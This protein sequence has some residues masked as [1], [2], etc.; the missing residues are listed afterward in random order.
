VT[1]VQTCALPISFS[2]KEK[3]QANCYWRPTLPV[4]QDPTPRPLHVP[5]DLEEFSR[6]FMQIWEQAKERELVIFEEE[7]NLADALKT[8]RLQLKA[9]RL[10]MPELFCEEYSKMQLIVTFLAVLELL[11][12]QEAR[13]IKEK[14]TWYF[15][16]Q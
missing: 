3:E 6:L 1:G 15:L 14:D 5:L 7:W 4:V 9:G 2:K 16:C 12:N 10:G 8:V 13:L 11:K